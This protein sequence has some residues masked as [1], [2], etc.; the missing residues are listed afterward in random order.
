MRIVVTGAKGQLG[1]DVEKIS[2]QE[3]YEVY[4]FGRKELDITNQSLVHETI[5]EIKPDAIIHCAA[6]TNVDQAENDE[7]TAFLV[8]AEGTKFLA[9]AAEIVGSKFLY[10]STDYVFNGTAN[11]PYQ[12]D[13]QKSPLGV[14]GRSKSLGEDYTLRY[15]SK[16]FIIRTSW[17]FGQN[18][19]NFVKTMLNLSEKHSELK[20]VDDQIGS[21]TYTYDLARLIAHIIDT[22]QYG[23]YH[24]TNAGECTWYEFAK[25]IF[26]LKEIDINVNPCTTEE[27]PRPAP[28]P[29]YSVLGSENLVGQ[30][31]PPLRH[32]KEA[33]RDYLNS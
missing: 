6:Y 20:V 10:I 15:S 19:N 25:T 30:S 31:S 21:P 2:K 26:Y 32:W 18:G 1:H 28:R 5:T 14:Y 23:V 27:F 16:C 12:A 33:L 11:S 3:G 8:N 17:V 4:A 24:G 7:E 29:S 9:Q 22:E 13:D